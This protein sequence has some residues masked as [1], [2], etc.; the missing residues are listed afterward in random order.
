MAGFVDAGFEAGTEGTLCKFVFSVL[1]SSLKF[2]SRSME[3]SSSATCTEEDVQTVSELLLLLS[4]VL[5]EHCKTKVSGTWPGAKTWL[6]SS[7]FLFLPCKLN[8]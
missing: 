2:K 6:R 5:V 8:P 4:E 1:S 7:R 3:H